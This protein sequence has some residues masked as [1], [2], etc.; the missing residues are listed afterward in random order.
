MYQEN[1]NMKNVK[2]EEAFA[3]LFKA[4]NEHIF[5]MTKEPKC[6]E[7]LDLDKTYQINHVC[8]WNKVQSLGMN[9]HIEQKNSSIALVRFDSGS[10]KET[11]KIK[12]MLDGASVLAQIYRLEDL[13]QL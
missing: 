6:V 12:K 13:T 10:R 9:V 1:K 7:E 4:F 5:D 8:A 2:S 3:N 11:N